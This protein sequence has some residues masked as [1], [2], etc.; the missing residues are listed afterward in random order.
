MLRKCSISHN[1]WH[2]W[3]RSF[4]VKVKS[5]IL[6]CT[7]PLKQ[8]TTQCSFHA[9]IPLEITEYS[10]K[11]SNLVS[12]HSIA[13]FQNG[14]FT[15][16]R[17]PDITWLAFRRIARF[18]H[19]FHWKVI[20]QYLLHSGNLIVCYGKWPFIVDLLIYPLKIVIFHSYVS[21][22]EGICRNAPLPSE[23]TRTKQWYQEFMT[24]THNF[25]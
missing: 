7:L 18:F 1:I 25:D 24:L 13:A 3:N 14:P 6:G 5:I 10:C 16:Y 22:P 21:L 15:L 11:C 9:E 2:S 23:T 20:F 19:T 8:Y 4:L 12:L 17:I